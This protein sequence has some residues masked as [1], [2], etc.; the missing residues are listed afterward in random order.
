MRFHVCGRRQLTQN[1]RHE[2]RGEMRG[3]PLRAPSCAGLR[4]AAIVHRHAPLVG[5]AALR[6]AFTM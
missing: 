2:G 5:I 3:V 1:L 6:I 4:Q